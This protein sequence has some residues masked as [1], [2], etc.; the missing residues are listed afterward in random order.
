LNNDTI[1]EPDFLQ[2]LVRKAESSSKPGIIGGKIYIKGTNPPQVWYGGGEIDWIQMEGRYRGLIE[3]DRGEVDDG[4]FDKEQK[5]ELISG[6]MMLVP[7]KVFEQVGL[8]PDEYFFGV[9]EWDFSVRVRKAGYDL[10]YVPDSVIWHKVT[11]SVDQ[12]FNE[13]W[14]IYN[15]ERSRLIFASNHLTGLVWYF[16]YLLHFVYKGSI[17][18]YDRW[19]IANN[20]PSLSIWDVIKI[21]INAEWDFYKKDAI[22]KNDFNNIQKKIADEPFFQEG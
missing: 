2:P 1:V 18:L 5:V 19:R 22:T 13:P 7:T 11:S 4:Q 21:S 15:L 17:G 20:H 12:S 9:E 16:W 3:E 6:C 14:Q 10:W 8:L